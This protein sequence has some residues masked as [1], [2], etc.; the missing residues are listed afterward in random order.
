[1]LAGS[2]GESPSSRLAF[3]AAALAHSLSTYFLD[4]PQMTNDPASAILQAVSD[5]V[6]GRVYEHLS[7]KGS[8][9]GMRLVLI[10]CLVVFVQV[11]VKFIRQSSEWI[12][13]KRDSH[14]ARYPGLFRTRQPKFITISRLAAS[15]IIF[16]LYFFAIGLMLQEFGVNLTAYLAG[17]SIIGLAISFGSQGLVQDIVSGITLITCDAMDIGD[18]VEIATSNTIV[19]G[20]VEEIGLRFTTL[21][22]SL[23]QKVLVPNRNIGTVSRF[24][25]G[26][27]DA[28]GNVRIPAGADPQKVVQ[29]VG[30][31]AK[32]MWEQFGAIILSEPMIGGVEKARGGGWSFFRIHFKILPGQGGLIE[33]TFRMRVVSAMKVFDPNYADWQVPVTYRALMVEEKLIPI[34]PFAKKEVP[35]GRARVMVEPSAPHSASVAPGV[36]AVSSQTAFAAAP[37]HPRT[38]EI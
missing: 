16:A 12:I 14:R 37:Q 15:A 34:L 20:R 27:V 18:L 11:A 17:A 35:T 25:P 6:V 22:N 2:A 28:Y 21:V 24:P 29:L 9:T 30:D 32:G 8:S 3:R 5:T 13:L 23:H 4:K 31:E 7:G 10:V 36:L 26:G 33:N 1:L 19:I 38:P